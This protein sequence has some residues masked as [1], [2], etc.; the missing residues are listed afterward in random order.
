MAGGPPPADWAPVTYIP[1][2]PGR[3]V[4]VG[5]LHGD[6]PKAME[7]LVLAGVVAPGARTVPDARWVG[8]DTL[9]VQ[10]GDFTDRGPFEFATLLLL[11]HVAHQARREGGDLVVLLGNHDLMQLEGDFRYVHR[12]A[13]EEL[14]RVLGYLLGKEE[15][16]EIAD[17]APGAD[18]AM[19]TLRRRAW[20]PGG[21]L[22]REVAKNP[23]A[24]V[25][26][27]T[28]FVHAGLTPAHLGEFGGDLR[29]LNR[30]VAQ[31]AAGGEVDPARLRPSHHPRMPVAP[32]ITSGSDSPVWTRVYA[33]IQDGGPWDA[34]AACGMLGETLDLLSA[35]WPGGSGPRVRR[36][37]VGHTPQVRQVGREGFEVVGI[38]GGCPDPDTGDPRVWRVDVGMSA[39]MYDADPEVLELSRGDGAEGV[40]ARVVRAGDGGGHEEL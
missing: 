25:V 10:V 3:V 37:V 21:P 29:E 24:L 1:S 13:M 33:P 5:D 4:A 32:R 36:M 7:A 18:R 15:L 39:G 14:V 26:G 28:A 9:V 40:T 34:D 17:R 35:A 2:H 30:T 11:R 22:A 19:G 8:G 16:E 23:V 27:D 6:L 20:A 12:G 38:N 31:W